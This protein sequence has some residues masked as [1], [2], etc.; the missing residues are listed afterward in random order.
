M[1]NKLSA[2]LLTGIF[3]ASSTLCWGDVEPMVKQ[4]Q[5]GIAFITGGVGS[6]ERAEL[7]KVFSEYTLR[8]ELANQKGEYLSRGQVSIVDS[9]GKEVL[10]TQVCGPWLLVNLPNG[11]YKVTVSQKDA[12]KNA[13]VT[14]E[15]GKIKVI[16][17]RF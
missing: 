15:R 17:V 14:V 2:F 8:L 13:T 5:N 9:G 1:T 10:K 7:K 6:D 16:I 4:T 11:Q 3:F 12:T